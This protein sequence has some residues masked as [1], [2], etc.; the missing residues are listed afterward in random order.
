MQ[1]LSDLSGRCK[2][3]GQLSRKQGSPYLCPVEICILVLLPK[4]YA[5]TFLS[6]LNSCSHS[7]HRLGD[8]IHEGRLQRSTANEKAVNVWLG[9]EV[10]A[11]VW[12]DAATILDANLCSDLRTDSGLQ[13]LSNGCLGLLSLVW[14]CNLACADSPDRLIGDH[15]EIPV[16]DLRDDGCELALIHLVRLAC[17]ALLQELSNAKDDLDTSLLALF[18]LH[19]RVFVGLAVL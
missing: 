13:V 18:H 11:I 7:P 3:Q 2:R 17:L 9:D 6:K 8:D 4:L 19:G 14:C 15:Y 1:D 16:L 5:V 12:G 10:C